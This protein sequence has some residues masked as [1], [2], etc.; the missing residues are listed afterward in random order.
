[1]QLD[2]LGAAALAMACL[3]AVLRIESGRTNDADCTKAY[4]DVIVGAVIFGVLTGRIA[5]MIIGGT[6]PLSHPADILII[7]GGVDTGFAAAG[8]LAAFAVLSRRSP[9]AIG[10]ALGPAAL[11][12]LAGWHASCAFR[13]LCAGT[14]TDLPWAI[15]PTGSVVGRHPVEI[16]AALLLVAS[17]AAL[18]L[19]KQHIPARRG[20][21]GGA[22][23]ALAA[24]I[25]LL[26]E[27]LRPG[28][29]SGPE[30]WYAAGVVAGLGL[31][32][33]R[34]VVERNAPEEP[35]HGC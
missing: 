15:H 3:Y 4:W 33:W 27:P 21:V 35:A 24:G 20:V 10:D 1:M 22:A 25:R 6:N 19:W 14:P 8:A 30:W 13:G 11:G 18:I 26:T 28:I 7:R 17:T 9:H 31:A 5:A 2:L 29:G 12:A 16:Y 23:V 34:I 32:V